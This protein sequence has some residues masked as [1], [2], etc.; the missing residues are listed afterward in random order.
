MELYQAAMQYEGVPWKHRGRTVRGMD[1]IGLI[2]QAVRDCGGT[3]TDRINYG[4]EPW[5]DGLRDEL[6][7]QFTEVFR[8][9]KVNDIILGS[10]RIKHPPVHTAIIA[11]YPFGGLGVVHS[12]CEAGSV[13]FTR[14]SDRHQR[15]TNG[16]F[17]WAR[18]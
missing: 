10:F 11:P 16:V 8:P 3:L 7:T 2:L 4:L 15:L 17:E 6:E 12:F 14:Y 1:C 18:A 9:P 5:R 13:V